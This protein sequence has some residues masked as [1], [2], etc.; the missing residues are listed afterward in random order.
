VPATDT[1]ADID[2]ART[3]TFGVRRARDCFHHAWWLDPIYL[4]RYPEGGLERYGPD[5][6]TVQPGDMELIHQPMDFCAVNYYSARTARAGSDGQP[7]AAPRLPGYPMT[8]QQDWAIVPEG[9]YYLTKFMHERYSLPIVI[10]ENGHQNNDFVMLDGKVH[11]QERIDYTRRHLLQLE[12]AIRDGVD[13][14]G[15]FHWTIMDNFEWAHGYKV[16]VGLVHVDY[17][18]QERT[19]KDSAHW[20][21]QVM[22]TNGQCLDEDLYFPP[23]DTCGGD[24]TW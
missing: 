12:R 1:E 19:P 21:T 11:D 20:Y 15:Y 3:L 10:T 8:A 7:E 5:A 9:I 23:A 24:R 4:G 6:P 13:V 18:T 14:H 17:E 22:A 16:R 2:G